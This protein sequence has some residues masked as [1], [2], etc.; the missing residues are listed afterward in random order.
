MPSLAPLTVK[1]ISERKTECL[2]RL[3]RWSSLFKGYERQ[4]RVLSLEEIRGHIDYWLDQ[5]LELRGL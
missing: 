1:P 4:N 5:L 2:D 3:T